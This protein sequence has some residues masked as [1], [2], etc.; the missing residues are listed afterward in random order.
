VT[1]FLH[2]QRIEAVRA[3]VVAERAASVVDLGCGD[4]DLLVRLAREEGIARLVGVDIRATALERLR[5]RL[6]SEDLRCGRI[7]LRLASV[8]DHDPG[9]AGFDCALLVEVIEHVRPDRLSQVERTVFATMRPRLAVVTTPNADFNALLGVPSERMRHPGH[10]FEWS[11][12]RF[13]AWAR[14][15]AGRTGYRVETRDIAGCHPELGGASQMAIFRAA[16][17]PAATGVAAIGEDCAPTDKGVRRGCAPS[18][19]AQGCS[20][21]SGRAT[22][23]P[24]ATASASSSATRPPA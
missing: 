7:D 21:S 1:S 10:R 8:V 5:G 22:P 3:V 4:G 12:Q 23:A 11:R 19:P 24:S 6:R 14:S 18:R 13:G 16:A 2:D 15:V 17:A 20:R 9:L